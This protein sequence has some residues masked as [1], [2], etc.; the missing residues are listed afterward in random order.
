MFAISVDAHSLT[1]VDVAS[2]EK[3]FDSPV[4][5]EALAVRMAG[6]EAEQQ[7]GPARRLH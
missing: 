7:A 5:S 2:A 3:A 6:R 4:R 1:S